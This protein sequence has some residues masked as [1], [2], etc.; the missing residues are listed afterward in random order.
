MSR[1][2]ID[3]PIFAW[4]IAIV[5]M[6]AGALA[7][8][9]LPI[10][11][12]P[13]IAPP[14]VSIQTTY[15]GA[16]AKTVEDSVTQILEQ[17]MT[18]I[19]NLLYMSSQSDSSG[20]VSISLNFTAG[21]DA[22]TAQVQV[23]NKVQQA[24]SSLPQA[25]QDQGVTVEKANSSFLMVVGLISD[26]GKMSQSDISDYLVTNIKE[27][28]SRLEG[29]GSVRVF[30]AQYAM[31]IWLDPNK[32]NSFSLS[33]SDVTSAITNQ[34]TQFSV[35]QLGA[36][37]AVP[38]QQLNATITA[39][40]R[41]TNTDEFKNI[42]LKVNTDGSQVR[43]R[44]VARVELGSEDYAAVARLNGKASSGIA[45]SLATG[46]NALET[47]NIVKAKM[48]ELSKYFPS[49]LKLVYPY[50]TT[51]FV[52]ISISEV[53]HT[54]IEAVVLVFLIMYLFLQNF[55][56][57]LI[58]SIAVPVV[59]L[60]TFGIMAVFGYSINTLT[61]FGLVLAIG[62]LVD[63]AIVVVENVERVMSE[64]GLSPLEATRK[65]MDQITGALVGIALVL[66]AVFVPMAFFSG[67]TGAIYRQFSVTI[68]S[69]MALSVVV[70]L[71]LTPALCAT[72]LKP[73]KK[74]DHG[75]Q[76]GFFGWF[77]RMF[78]RNTRRYRT[79]VGKA[80]Q[81]SGRMLIIYAVLLGGVVFFFKTLPSSFLPEEDQGALMVMV[82]L[83]TGA[84]QE[85]TLKV[86]DQV[87]DYFNTAEKD[88]IET[89][90]TIAGFSFAG[91]GQNMGLGFVKLKDWSERT[92][93]G[94]DSTSIAGRAMGHFMKV[95]DASI[96][97]LNLPAIREL[98]NATGFDLYLQDQGGLG[99]DKLIQA[100]NQLLGM[101]AKDPML[102]RV[103]PN[104][105]EDTPEYNISIDYEK[106]MALGLSVSDINSTL[107]IAWGSKYV[108][109]FIDRGR[110][111]TV[112]VQ[113]DAPYRMQPEHL[114]LWYVKNTTDQMVPF[115]AFA[116]G[117]WSYG[118]PSLQR[119]NG[120]SAVEIVGESATGYSSGQ[121][122]TEM[123]KLISQL[124]AGIGFE[125]TGLSYQE[126]VSGS[127]APALYAIS[128]LVVFLCLAALYESWSIPFSVML[129]VPLGVFGALLA[130]SLRSLS[131]DIFFQVGLLTTIGLSAK[132]AILIVEFAKELFDKG[133]G[134][135]QAVIE[136][137]RI[138]LRPILMTSMAFLLGVFPLVIS[139]GA[140]ANG[141]HAIG[142]GV[143]GGMIAATVL[144]IFF[145]PSFFVLV[146]KYFSKYRKTLKA[147]ITA[148]NKHD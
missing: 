103:R 99:H 84:T 138:R 109:D 96:F 143:T 116:K 146:M 98:G 79:M 4:V 126:Q 55:R 147:P 137:S 34:N 136:A 23:Q 35:G 67:S 12:Y 133:M 82:Q 43:L 117:N 19:D 2:F 127:Q 8:N 139:T 26:D 105:M 119:Y 108:N 106:A 5:I 63:D 1:F 118:S 41:L 73:I 50:D 64:E 33:P 49:G 3:R 71:I 28:L 20:R 125:W 57:T 54:L 25:V 31:R 24:L 130:A 44:D 76:K 17:N 65:S 114:N 69:A 134:L 60:G 11:Q 93:P 88:N 142:T 95:K 72:M 92:A 129:I 39:Q 135:K 42:L 27:P 100:R 16:S 87:S 53:A 52:K 107:S 22:D 123:A 38:G 6:L 14:S 46:A 83:P 78:D 144:A 36:T 94:S 10:E 85:R 112:Y 32:L 141:R 101:A 58:P 111:K 81:H 70:A 18:G 48:E 148:E 74:G 89:V 86:L 124:P 62:L 121:A 75:I 61:M 40:G 140:G 102:T 21:T 90:F 15:P 97:A 59:L 132:N 91:S 47:A 9:T 29:V 120:S 56:A 77:N 45:V 131:N 104:G 128:L 30:G 80:L 115:S 68:V 122:M 7:I 37:P 113:S 13:T 110:V 66:S 51:T 145:V